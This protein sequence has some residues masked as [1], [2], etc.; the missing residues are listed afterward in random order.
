MEGYL[1]TTDVT[2]KW[3]MTP[4]KAAMVF[5]GMYGGIDGAHHKD[6]VLDQVSRILMKA[7]VTINEA[8]W[9][10]GETELRYNVGTSAEYEEWVRQ[11]KDGEDGP[12]SYDYSEGIAP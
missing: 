5:I 4:E 9:S 3:P 11:Q 1:G 2:D 7:P 12:D 10:N 6:W 8:R